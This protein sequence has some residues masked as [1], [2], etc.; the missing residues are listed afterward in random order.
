MKHAVG[1]D[2]SFS[3][4]GVVVLDERGRHVAKTFSAGSRGPAIRA[5]IN[6]IN[7]LVENVISL[8]DGLDIAGLCIEGYAMGANSSNPMGYCDLIELGGLIRADLCTLGDFP[9]W[10]VTT[11]T[12]KMF[13]VGRGHTSGPRKVT[14]RDMI[15]GV[16]EQWGVGLGD[17]NQ[18]DAYGLAALAGQAAGMFCPKSAIQ[19]KAIETISGREIHPEKTI[20]TL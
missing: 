9:I 3:G 11:G 15:D 18:A 2:P 19:S 16:L 5:R 10:E 6:R 8:L 1:I 14:K 7:E 20:A 13:V 4:C 17:H 12:L